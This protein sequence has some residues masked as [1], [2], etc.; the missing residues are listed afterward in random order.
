MEE[1]A[2]IEPGGFKIEFT[3]LPD[4]RLI[5]SQEPSGTGGFPLAS[6]RYV[7][8]IGVAVNYDGVV[9]EMDSIYDS[10]FLKT[11]A[12]YLVSDREGLFGRD[13]PSCKKYFRTNCLKRKL[14]CPYC[15]HKDDN[16]AFT[17][18]NQKR[19]MSAC[20]SASL[21]ARI[22]RKKT[23][24]DTG[25][26]VKTLPNNKPGWVYTEEN[27]QH[28]F[29]CGKCKEYRVDIVFNILGEFGNCPSCGKRNYSIVFE[30]KI[31]LL[32]RQFAEKNNSVKDQRLREEEWKSLLVRCVSEFEYLANDVRKQLLRIPASP[33]RKS[34][35]GSLSFQSL[36]NARD[37]IKNWFGIEILDVFSE[38]DANFMNKMF[39]RRH[40]V[41]HKGSQV[42]EEYIKNT[43]DKTVRLNQVIRIGSNEVNRLISLTKKVGQNL[44]LG[45]ESIQ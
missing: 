27:Q 42:D 33:R 20:C 38:E 30:S 34:D 8:V 9:L 6:N 22:K 19:F 26:I 29:S 35:L 23:I 4:G 18:D 10:P 43:G 15:S 5:V 44:I 1:F 36:L 25:D 45:F 21:E 7:R 31:K 12:T 32:E 11:F 3:P 16:G 13:C 37:C 17:T 40:L 2:E 28:T 24:L 14:I 41:I 39:N